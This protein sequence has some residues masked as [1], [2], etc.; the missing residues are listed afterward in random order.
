MRRPR[1]KP[2]TDKNLAA[3]LILASLVGMLVAYLMY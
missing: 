1:M 2:S 3:A